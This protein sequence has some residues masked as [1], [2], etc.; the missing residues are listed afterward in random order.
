MEGKWDAIRE[1]Q[2]LMDEA[3]ERVGERI[4]MGVKRKVLM[5]A[6]LVEVQEQLFKVPTREWKVDPTPKQDAK[7]YHHH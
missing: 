4:N 7:F 6:G 5:E 2:G 3:A 1:W